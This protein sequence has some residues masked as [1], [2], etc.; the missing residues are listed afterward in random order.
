MVDGLAFDDVDLFGGEL[1]DPL[2]ELEQDLWH[3]L[4]EP[5][6]S[7]PDDLDRGVGLIGM[8]SSGFV[9]QGVL[10]SLIAADFKKDKRVANIAV[11][12]TELGVGQYRIDIAVVPNSDEVPGADREINLIALR[13][14]SG[15]ISRP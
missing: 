3:R 7:N 13:D 8:L 2:A 14:A 15:A 6:G 5:P 1:D 12:V 9:G 4:I 11:N 10:Q